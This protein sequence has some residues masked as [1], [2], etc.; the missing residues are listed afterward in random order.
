MESGR[1]HR[2]EGSVGVGSRVSRQHFGVGKRTLTEGLAGP[3]GVGR[4]EPPTFGVGKRTLTE[5]LADP[6]GVGEGDPPSK[7]AKGMDAVDAVLETV[8]DFVSAVAGALDIPYVTHTTSDKS[9]EGTSTRTRVGVGELVTFKSNMPGRWQAS[10]GAKAFPKTAMGDQFLWAAMNVKGSVKIT[11]DA[12]KGHSPIDIQMDVIEPTVDYL[13][14]RAVAFPGQAPGVAGVLME[15]DVTFRPMEVSF[16]NTMWWERP[17]PASGATGYFQEH[18]TVRHRKLPYHHPNPDDLQIEAG[19]GGPTDQAGWWDFNGPFK[20]GSF[21]W[22]IP[23]YYKV[24][25]D[26]ERHLI[27]NVHQRCDIAADGTMTVTKESATLSRTP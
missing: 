3:T 15:T 17:G 2:D 9:P 19:N 18:M 7:R 12:G 4:G 10:N 27:K 20:P 25:D 14:P 16:A 24:V 21:E 23:T 22:V 1:R 26:G 11:F 13:K 6:T 5:R 8:N